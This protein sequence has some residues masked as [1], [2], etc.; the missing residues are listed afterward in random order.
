MMSVPRGLAEAIFC[1]DRS[2][3]EP[4]P[5]CDLSPHGTISWV[6][7]RVPQV[8]CLNPLIDRRGRQ[9]ELL[10]GATICIELHNLIP[11]A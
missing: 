11:P 10:W 3:E 5:N 4:A 2:R 6:G 1:C 7:R 8:A 9:Q